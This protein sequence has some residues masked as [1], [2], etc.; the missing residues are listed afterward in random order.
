MKKISFF[1]LAH[2]YSHA[3]LCTSSSLSPAPIRIVAKN[4]TIYSQKW[5]FLCANIL[6]SISGD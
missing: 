5:L 2:Y 1:A 3:I 6:L 4:A